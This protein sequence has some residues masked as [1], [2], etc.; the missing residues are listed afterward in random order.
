M[1]W[2]NKDGAY[3]TE[4]SAQLFLHDDL[5]MDVALSKY[6]DLLPIER[7]VAMAARNGLEGLPGQSLIGITHHLANFLECVYERLK[8]EILGARVIHADETPH[9]MLEGEEEIKRVGFCGVLAARP[10]VF[11]K[12]KI[13]VRVKSQ[14]RF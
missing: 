5:V 8:E 2:G 4:D 12:S 6:C 9:K 3:P 1:S 13:P 10:L 7:Y 11:L 14:S